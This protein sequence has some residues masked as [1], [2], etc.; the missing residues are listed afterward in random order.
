MKP[1]S[2]ARMSEI[3]VVG[4]SIRTRYQD[5]SAA[6]EVSNLWQKF[7]EEKIFDKIPHKAQPHRIIALYTDHDKAGSCNLILGAPVNQYDLE[8]M[9]NGMIFKTILAAHY[10]LF[11]DEG[12]LKQIV[13]TLWKAIGE[14]KKLQR[15]FAQ[16]FELYDYPIDVNNGSVDIYVGVHGKL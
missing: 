15:T 9:P 10:A 12:A 7:H 6:R 8:T 2:F 11:S 13:P 1:Q 14:D 3:K 16:D 4:I 5:P